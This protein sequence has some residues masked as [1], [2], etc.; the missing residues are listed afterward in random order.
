MNNLALNPLE[1][2]KID[3]FGMLYHFRN[4]SEV[5]WLKME[6]RGVQ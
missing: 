5:S 2:D 4:L 3:I 1:V 6:V